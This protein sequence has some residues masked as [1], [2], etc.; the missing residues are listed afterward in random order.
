MSVAKQSLGVLF[1]GRSGE[2][3]ISIRSSRYVVNSVDRDRFELVLVGIDRAGGW[4][5]CSETEYGA[6]DQEVHGSCGTVVVPVPSPGR[7][8]LLDPAQP[9]R[10]LP[11]IDV[12]FPILHGP[13]GEDGTIQGL[14]EMLDVAYVGVGVLGAAVCMD[15]DVS[16]RLLRDAGIPVVPFEVVTSARWAREPGEVRAAA[17]R[18]GNPLFVKPANLGSSLGV[19]K[20]S[21]VSEVDAAIERALALDTKILIER[22]IDGR[23]IECAV[24]GND[25]PRASV[26]GEIVPG[27]IFYSFDDKYAAD[28]QAR[29]LIPAPLSDR[30]RET[31]QAF[32][33]RAFSALACAGMARVDFFLE[34]STEQLYLNELNTIPG[35]TSISMYPK[36]WEASGVAGQALVTR[37]IELA[38]DRHAARRPRN[39]R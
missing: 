23:E 2:H 4:H 29:L 7:C 30:L 36:L 13:Y 25:E 28:S 27:E 16:K 32:A 12:V 17:A 35:F 39:G 26:P 15:K 8:G 11:P 24:L 31:V 5:L 19:S 18:L 38:L 22:A 6:I 3:A 37:L 33:V 34:K 9:T 14:L 20:A 21:T 10:A 1:G